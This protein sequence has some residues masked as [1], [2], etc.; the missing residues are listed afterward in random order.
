MHSRNGTVANNTM[1]PL[2]LE[3]HDSRI[4]A[5]YNGALARDGPRSL[6]HEKT[7]HPHAPIPLIPVHTTTATSESLASVEGVA[8]IILLLHQAYYLPVLKSKEKGGV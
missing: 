7:S 2:A 5:K 4:N 3:A 6:A 1:A 8:R